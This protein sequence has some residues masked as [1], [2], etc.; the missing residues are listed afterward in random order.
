M[1]PVR[2]KTYPLVPM[3]DK[4]IVHAKCPD[5]VHFQEALAAKDPRAVALLEVAVAM[6]DLVHEGADDNSEEVRWLMD[7]VDGGFKGPAVW[8]RKRRAGATTGG[9]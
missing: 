6:S 4:V 1:R 9:P 5:A 2:C 7:Y 3:R 8:K